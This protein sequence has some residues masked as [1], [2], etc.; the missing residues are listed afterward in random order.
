MTCENMIYCVYIYI[1]YDDAS[2]ILPMYRPY[3]NQQG[4]ASI[5]CAHLPMGGAERVGKAYWN[6]REHATWC[7][8]F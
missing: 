3:I 6:P 5:L 2:K 1:I 7:D 8:F 4:E